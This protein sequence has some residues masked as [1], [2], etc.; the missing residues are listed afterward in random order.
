MTAGAKIALAGPDG[1]IDTLWASPTDDGLYSLDNVPWYALRVSEG[2][3]VEALPDENGRLE[4]KRVVRKSGNR[5][6]RVLL[7]L[8]EP[9]RERIAHA[10]HALLFDPPAGELRR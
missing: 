8:T 2:D 6:V 4:M 7:E 10:A 1:E 9:A 5:T 3:V